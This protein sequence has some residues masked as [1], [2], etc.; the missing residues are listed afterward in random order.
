M[1][2]WVQILALGALC[3]LLTGT[4][5]LADVDVKAIDGGWQIE[6]KNEPLT[7]VL[8]AISKTA[9]IKISGTAKL[10]ENPMINGVY[11]GSLDK[12]LPRL[13]RSADYA[14]IT[15]TDKN[16]QSHITRLVLLS[17]AKGKAPSA[18]AM[19]AARKLP[20]ARRITN[21][22]PTA[23]DK[24][25]GARVTS[26][27]TKRVQTVAGVEPEANPAAEPEEDNAPQTSG[28]TRNADGGF[29][30]TPEAQARMAEATRRAQQDLQALVSAIR[31]NDN[32]SG[33]N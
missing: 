26:L 31:R 21:N 14:F 5:V 7:G 9:G 6:A 8:D 25:Q 30:I 24:E 32:Q 28:I 10:I 11:K 1:Q 23:K 16:G 13:L 27:L 2:N 22:A 3:A 18:R 33:D 12:V 4:A 17:G 20:A 15:G 29:D 19:T